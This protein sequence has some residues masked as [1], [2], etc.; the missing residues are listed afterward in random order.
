MR[1][2]TFLFQ[3]TPVFSGLHSCEV[4]CT[5]NTDVE[6]KTY[7]CT[8]ILRR[9]PSILVNTVRKRSSPFRKGYREGQVERPPPRGGGCILLSNSSFLKSKGGPTLLNKQVYRHYRRDRSNQPTFG[10]NEFSTVRSEKIDLE[11]NKPPGRG[12]LSDLH[13]FSSLYSSH[14]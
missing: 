5:V 10:A 6:N 1:V 7:N 9:S 3:L 14:S 11:K 2:K 13:G 4:A 8:S 12:D